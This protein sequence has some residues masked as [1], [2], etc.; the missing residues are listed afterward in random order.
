MSFQDFFIAFE[1]N[2]FAND[3]FRDAVEADGAAAYR[4]WGE[5]GIEGAFFID[6]GG[7]SSGVFEGVHFAVE[8]GALFLDSSIVSSPDDVSIVDDNTPNGDATFLQSDFG[9]FYGFFHE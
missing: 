9:F 4:A 7:E 6:R 5:G 1:S 8:D 3:D 2:I